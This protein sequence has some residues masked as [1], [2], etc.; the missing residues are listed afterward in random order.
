MTPDTLVSFILLA[1]FLLISLLARIFGA[2][3]KE[4]H[5]R[6][7]RSQPLESA[8]RRLDPR[9]TRRPRRQVPLPRGLTRST[10][11]PPPTRMDTRLTVAHRLSL[12]DRRALRR[13][14]VL[15]TLLGPCRAL[16]AK[17]Y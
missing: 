14:V 11:K 5:Q 2:G 17:L 7:A 10:E 3:Q 12:T 9:A 4:E 1:V 8:P 13:A 16:D 15:M 6:E